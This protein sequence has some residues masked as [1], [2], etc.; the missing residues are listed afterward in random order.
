MAAIFLKP[1]LPAGNVPIDGFEFDFPRPA[2]Q[3][4]PHGGNRPM[5]IMT[6]GNDWLLA[7]TTPA[8]LR[9]QNFSG[10]RLISPPPGQH[11]EFLIPKFSRVDFDLHGETVGATELVL[12]DGKG[13]TSHVLRISVKPKILKRFA[14]FML[15][16]IRRSSTRTGQ[17][18][19]AVMGIVRDL[20]LDQAN[21]HLQSI[22]P[23]TGL[24]VMKD[25]NNPVLLD[26]ELPDIQKA[27][28]ATSTDLFVYCVWNVEDSTKPNIRAAG[29]TGGVRS[30]VD[31][32]PVFPSDDA[33]QA[34]GHE[35]GH[36]LGL[37]HHGAAD[38]L[39]FKSKSGGLKLGRLQ[40]DKIN[41]FGAG[42]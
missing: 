18:V 41:S 7:R 13:T 19:M 33:T 3:M 5:S 40:I 34:F 37:D 24:L 11:G 42:P 15:S 4:V 28:P 10:S 6:D 8:I 38:N 27:T 32:G 39:M 17:D 22:G 9:L 23:P 35:I 14:V 25:L 29:L 21:L 2:Y 12:F 16:D 31:D 30:F 1:T 26:K 20:F 36:A